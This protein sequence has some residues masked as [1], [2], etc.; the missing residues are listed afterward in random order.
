MP[1]SKTKAI[2]VESAKQNAAKMASLKRRADQKP[3]GEIDAIG[4]DDEERQAQPDET[5]MVVMRDPNAGERGHSEGRPD[6][7]TG[8]PSILAAHRACGDLHCGN[9]KEQR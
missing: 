7:Q 2:A 1:I 9:R 8:K 3:C 6:D 5:R 4:Q